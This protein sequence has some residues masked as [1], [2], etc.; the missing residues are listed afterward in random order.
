MELASEM[1][2]V[3][4]HNSPDG[5]VMSQ[6]QRD[7]LF[8][9]GNVVDVVECSLH[10][11]QP[12]FF[13]RVTRRPLTLVLWG[14]ADRYGV[15]PTAGVEVFEVDRWGDAHNYCQGLRPHGEDWKDDEGKDHH[16]TVWDKPTAVAALQPSAAGEGEEQ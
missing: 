9:T 4:L 13:K 6:Q 16:W 1:K 7:L 12:E 10:S 11:L 8:S 3:V 15:A 14:M 5:L 2:Y